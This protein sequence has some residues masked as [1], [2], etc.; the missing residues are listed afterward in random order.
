M[1]KIIILLV[2]ILLTSSIYS[3]N[4]YYKSKRILKE[5]NKQFSLL[6]Y[7]YAI[8]LYKSYLLNIKA[9]NKKDSSVLKNLAEAY[10][11]VN[12]YDS[13]LLYFDKASSMGAQVKNQIAELNAMIG[14]YNQAQK[15]YE[16]IV[17]ENKTLLNV[18]RLYG[19]KNINKF[20]DDSL[21]YKIFTTKLNTPYNEFNA[22]PYKEGIV[23][24][25]NRIEV[26]RKKKKIDIISKEFKW[27]GAS[28]T[29]LYYLKNTKDI[30]FDTTITSKYQDKKLD[31][32]EI[33]LSTS[34]DTK[35][36]NR[37]IDFKPYIPK[38]DSTIELFS[39]Q[40]PGHLNIGAITFTQDGNTAY[41]TTNGHKSK[42]GYLLEIW[43]AKYKEGKWST[44]KLFFNKS[45][46][47]YFHPSIT[48]DGQRLFYVSDEMGGFGGTDIYYIDKNPDGSWKP[49]TNIGQEINTT[50]NELFPTFYE[51]SLYFSSNGHP[52]L[53]GLDIFRVTFDQRGEAIIKNLGY[54]IN[55]SKDDFGYSLN[56]NTGYFS[57]NRNGSDD[58]FAFDYSPKY[59]ELKGQI[60]LDSVCVTGRMVY[61]TKVNESGVIKIIDSAVVDQNCNY[62]FK[63]RP[64]QQY[65]LYSY[66]VTGHKFETTITS[67]QYLKNENGYVKNVD[68]INIPSNE[69]VQA[70]IIAKESAIQKLEQ[71]K[72][73][74]VFARTIDSLKNITKDY[75]ELHHPFN[76]VYII[77]K[78][79]VN[80]YKVIER[81][82]RL[83]NKK[84]V[85]VSA[86]DCNGSFEYNEDLSSRR[87]NRIYKTLSKL[88]NNEVVVKNV[89]E[90]ELLKACD[91][92]N[93]SI[94]EQVVN[95][96]SY[97]FI[98]DK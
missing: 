40:F 19:F 15:I 7:A 58:I 77:E 43:E 63:V 84:I 30:K 81:V 48:P 69:K 49:T 20:Y 91:D 25:S 59:I 53:G 93:K 65:S 75:V 47:N 56:A 66:D 36:I 28:Y 29:Q 55:S 54:P 57:S 78:D 3:Q 37:S 42:N 85:I 52:G 76:Q 98:V 26:K 45:G 73:T 86:A 8:P 34:N 39:K 24:E 96:Y 17:D 11:M 4:G 5:A 67:N 16:T 50:G 23:F 32:N 13:A 88:S 14:N 21:D 6:K 60:N 62:S 71:S 94:E 12:V 38:W 9:P 18:A 68:L 10:R 74:A 83:K 33:M 46:F 44:Y 87:A 79:L 61:L 51:G 41:Y 22:V 27:D 1:K 64:N 82:K 90:R 97:I 35:L 95:R 31:L 92:L 70:A 89:G 2:I 72:M 80:Y